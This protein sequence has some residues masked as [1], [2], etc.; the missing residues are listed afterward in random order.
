MIREDD[1]TDEQKQ[2]HNVLVKG[3][4]TFLSGWGGAEGGASVAAWAC[5]PDDMYQVERWVR[6]R[7]DMRYVDIVPDTYRPPRSTAHYHIYVADEN[8][9]SLQ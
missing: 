8:H 9:P 3:K 5:T 2:T 6:N 4:D 1:R 7:G